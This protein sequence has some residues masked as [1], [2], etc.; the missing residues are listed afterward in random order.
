MARGFSDA[1]G[2]YSVAVLGGTNQ[3][4]ASPDSFDPLLMN[5]I[6]SSGDSVVLSNG[7]SYLLN[8]TALP[9]TAKISGQVQ[10]NAGNPVAGVALSGNANIGELHYN[11]ANVDTDGAGNYTFGVAAGQWYVHF[12][13]NGDSSENLANQGLEDLNGP[14]YVNIPPTNALLNITVY[15]LGT[16]VLSA[17]ARI[18]PTQISLNVTGSLNTTYTLQVSTNLALTDCS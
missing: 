17:P 4:N 1:N 7:Q 11:S 15:P 10:D 18:S 2:N 12:T 9:T 16:P 8:F 14:Y 5:Y 13:V 3:W 6:V